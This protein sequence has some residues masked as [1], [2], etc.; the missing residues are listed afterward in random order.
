MSS[1]ITNYT[2]I[3]AGGALYVIGAKTFAD[4]H[5]NVALGKHDTFQ[6]KHATAI[7]S[8]ATLGGL[9]L[10][11]FGTYRLNKKVGMAAGLG[12]GTLLAYNAV[13]HA[14]GEPLISLSPF[15]PKIGP[16]VT[17]W[18]LF[19]DVFGW[20]DPFSG[21]HAPGHRGFHSGEGQH[22]EHHREEHRR[23]EEEHRR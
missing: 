19:G 18:N 23:H 14:K 8:V 22:D 21:Q 1:K 15:A 4:H 17:G 3:A 13:K 16:H 9:G 11:V 2:L 5:E 12:L 6:W 20:T 10:A 7:G